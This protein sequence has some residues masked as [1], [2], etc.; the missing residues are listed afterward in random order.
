MK[1]DAILQK[2]VQD[3]LIWEPQLKGADIGVITRD[4]IVTLTGTVDSYYK[5]TEAEKVVK[6]VSGVKA[7]VEKIT[8]KLNPEKSFNDTYI[9]GKILELF[10][11]SF[12]I[13]D[14]SIFV[15]VEKGWVTLEGTVNWNYQ[16]EAA[17]NVVAGLMGVCGITNNITTKSDRKDAVK[18]MP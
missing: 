13:P 17:K 15:F 4:G 3:A 18:K 6:K 14:E 10:R 5:K 9:A 8:V 1:T 11:S 12:S 7:L 2:E 16:K